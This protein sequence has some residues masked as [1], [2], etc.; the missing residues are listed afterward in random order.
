[1]TTSSMSGVRADWAAIPKEFHPASV[2]M[3]S[4]FVEIDRV[5]QQ[6]FTKAG[7]QIDALA[8]TSLDIGRGEFVG[9]IGPSGCGKTTLMKILAG[10]QTATGG[11]IRFGSK[12]EGGEIHRTS[13]VLQT[14]VL[15]PWLKLMDNVLLPIRARGQNAEPFRA[16]AA[17]LLEMV[18][19]S[20]FEGKYPGELSGGMQ[21]RA[22]LVR[23][24]I[25]DPALLLMDEPFGALDALTRDRMNVELQRIWQATQK[26][27]FFITH[28]I[29]EAVFLSD[30]VMVMSPRPGRIVETIDIPFE[31]PRSLEIMNTREFGKIVS[32]M[33]GLLDRGQ[34]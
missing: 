18:G 2:R 17:G 22:S 11:Q 27:I 29:N 13:V 33:R 6:Y 28:G 31:R 5:S 25:D 19:L 20:G 3:P 1:M 34:Q 23:A 26:T 32:H 10:I 15:M 8:E 24:L 21:Q 12:S 7:D 14:P 4:A 30:R 9:V 16:R